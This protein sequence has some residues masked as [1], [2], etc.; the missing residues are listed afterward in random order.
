M[1]IP[2]NLKIL[3]CETGVKKILTLSTSQGLG[4]SEIEVG[5]KSGKES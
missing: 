1:Q 2:W 4:E 3:I 5:K